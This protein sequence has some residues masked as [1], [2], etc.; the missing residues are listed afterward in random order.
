MREKGPLGSFVGGSLSNRP[1]SGLVKGLRFGG[2]E[3]WHQNWHRTARDKTVLSVTTTPIR[4]WKSEGNKTIDDAAGSKRIAANAFRDRPVRPLR[5]LSVS[6]SCSLPSGA[7]Q[8][9]GLAGLPTSRVKFAPATAKP[10][11]SRQSWLVR[12]LRAKT[13]GSSCIPPR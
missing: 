13:T 9:F 4:S 8:P 10:A 1:L 2:G 11:T 12:S 3:N 7:P 5:H 6:A